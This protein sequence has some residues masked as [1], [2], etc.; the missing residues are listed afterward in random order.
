MPYSYYDPQ[1]LVHQIFKEK[2]I[3]VVVLLSS[4][5]ECRVRAQRDLR[6]EYENEG[7][8]VIYLPVNDFGTLTYEQLDIAVETALSEIEA[9]YNLA[10]HCF[11]GCGRTGMFAACLA[12]RVFCLSGEEAI[13]WIRSHVS[14]AIE[15]TKQEEAVKEYCL[16]KGYGI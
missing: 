5:A 15:A 13:H 8:K 10:I 3:A 7:I 4:I 6:Q 1:N 9:G 12:G 2:E 16:R 14:C 11:A